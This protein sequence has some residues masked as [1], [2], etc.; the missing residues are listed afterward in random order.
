MPFETISS[1]ITFSIPTAGTVNWQSSVRTAFTAISGHTHE[2]GGTG[3]QLGTNSL[4]DGAVT[5]VKLAADAVTGT[6]LR[7]DNNQWFRVRNAA[8]TSDHS[9]FRVD[10]SDR[11]EINP[12]AIFSS[13]SLTLTPLT[14]DG[15]D[16]QS[17]SFCGGGALGS[18]RGAFFQLFGNEHS[19]NAGDV[20]LGCGNITGGQ[21]ILQTL[22]TQEIV[23]QTNGVT[24]WQLGASTGHLTP[25]A[26]ATYSVG[27]S[28]TGV[29]ALYL[30]E[31]AEPLT[32]SSTG[33]LFVDSSGNL[34]FK[35]K[36]GNVTTLANV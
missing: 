2:G 4:N 16:I 6:K 26:T 34:K 12:N 35:S 10:A 29:S 3:L 33:A 18:S 30:G 27:V 19:T 15:A 31:V 20:I 1:G 9:I 7:L 11:L 13:A 28:G 17:L 24:R 32:P 23:L 36:N 14:S 21:I 8:N 25:G 5:T 22:G